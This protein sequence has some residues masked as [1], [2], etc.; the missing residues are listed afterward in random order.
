[1]GVDLWE[2]HKEVLGQWE[3]LKE[4]LDIWEDLK[5]DLGLWEDIWEGTGEGL[6]HLSKTTQLEDSRGVQWEKEVHF[7]EITR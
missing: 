7:W 1:M 5:E 3:D 2:G 4:D 6:G